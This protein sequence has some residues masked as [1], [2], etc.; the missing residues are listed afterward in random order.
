MQERGAALFGAQPKSEFNRYDAN[1]QLAPIDDRRQEAYAR[2]A[3][4][5]ATQV[6]P[7][8]GNVERSLQREARAR[9]RSLI[10]ELPNQCHP[11]G[12]A[13]RW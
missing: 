11:M 12:H 3:E 2:A 6:R 4:R 7:L 5:Y 13:T 8:T 10:E 1:E 9:D